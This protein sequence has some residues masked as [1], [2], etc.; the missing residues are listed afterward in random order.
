M[1]VPAI[2]WDQPIALCFLMLERGK[3]MGAATAVSLLCNA[4]Y[5]RAFG[6]EE[7]IL[8]STKSAR[9]TLLLDAVAPDKP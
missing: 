6:R 7:G 9:I 4:S 5:R 1:S 3:S 8:S 2:G